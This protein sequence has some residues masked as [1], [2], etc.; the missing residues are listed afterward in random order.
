MLRALLSRLGTDRAGTALTELAISA[1]VLI[2]LYC[3]AYSLS[4][5]MACDRKVV[6]AAR[7]LA[8]VTSRYAAVTGNDLQTILDTSVYVMQPYAASKAWSRI[9]ELQVTDASH[10]RVVWSRARNGTALTVGTT[11]DLPANLAPTLMQPDAATKRA[12]AFFLLGEA[13]YTYT[14]VFGAEIM[15]APRLAAK[16]YML[17]RLSDSVPLA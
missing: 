12:G 15:P 2:L 8:D 5:A 1:P 13:G 3:G 4:D 16:I 7:A 14:P 9:S 11:V 10:A 17:P 6:R